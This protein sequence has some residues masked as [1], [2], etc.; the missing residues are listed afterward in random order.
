MSKLHRE[1][2]SLSIP[3]MALRMGIEVPAAVLA[4]ATEIIE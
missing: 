4:R 3:K 1:L 2:S